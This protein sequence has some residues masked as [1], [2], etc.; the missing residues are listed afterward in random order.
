MNKEELE[1]DTPAEVIAEATKAVSY[2][3]S[4][5]LLQTVRSW[6]RPLTCVWISLT[7]LTNGVV[8][9]L[10]N[11]IEKTGTATDMTALSLL[12]TAVTGS[13]AVREWGKTKGNA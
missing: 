2:V 11:M 10:Y 4:S 13:F 12:V 7:V 1:L 6:W 5:V 8:I 9:P 3:N